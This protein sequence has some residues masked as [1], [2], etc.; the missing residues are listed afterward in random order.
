MTPGHLAQMG[1]AFKGS[2]PFPRVPM[3]PFEAGQRWFLLSQST[4]DR[5]QSY[6]T[7]DACLE[8]WRGWVEE[9]KD[10]NKMGEVL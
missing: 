4:P 5:F 2:A 7:P 3:T 1:Q 6:S 8:F 9:K 10:L